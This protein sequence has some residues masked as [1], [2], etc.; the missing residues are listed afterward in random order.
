[1]PNTEV[2]RVPSSSNA[3][4]I[5][6]VDGAALPERETQRVRYEIC[7]SQQVIR[8]NWPLVCCAA[9]ARR[10]GSSRWSRSWLHDGFAN[11]FAIRASPTPVASINVP[12]W[13][14]CGTSSEGNSMEGRQQAESSRAGWQSTQHSRR[15]GAAGFVE[16]L[17]LKVSGAKMVHY[18]ILI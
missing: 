2:G 7:S 5:D 18:T 16:T 13:P 8:H 12:P 4:N 14:L 15:A 10:A 1:M 11:F 6:D 9:A 3:T 17:T